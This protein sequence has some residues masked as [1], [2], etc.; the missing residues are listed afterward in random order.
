MKVMFFITERVGNV[1]NIF[2][3]PH[4]KSFPTSVQLVG[5]ILHTITCIGCPYLLD[6]S[7]ASLILRPIF[8]EPENTSIDPIWA[9]NFISNIKRAVIRVWMWEMYLIDDDCAGAYVASCNT[10]YIG[11]RIKYIL[12]VSANYQINR[13]FYLYQIYFPCLKIRSILFF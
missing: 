8:F 4:F 11:W 6:C 9:M 1:P 2:F 10:F 3:V 13:K 5:N 12:N 7:F